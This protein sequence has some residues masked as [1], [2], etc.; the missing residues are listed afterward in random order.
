[1]F[2]EISFRMLIY[3]IHLP[4]VASRKIADNESRLE[5]MTDVENFMFEFDDLESLCLFS[6][7]DESEYNLVGR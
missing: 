2:Y 4:S 6:D 3:F 1:M 7:K 5:E